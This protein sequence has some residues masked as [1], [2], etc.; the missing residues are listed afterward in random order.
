MAEGVI[1][2]PIEATYPLEQVREALTH[3]A[4]SARQGKIL[5]LPNPDLLAPL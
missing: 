2:V 3:A 4:Q 1:S 5:L